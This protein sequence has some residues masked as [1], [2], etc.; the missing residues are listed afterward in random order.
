MNSEDLQEKQKKAG[1]PIFILIIFV[2]LI[3]FVFYVPEI[4]KKYNSEI[5]KFFGIKDPDEEEREKYEGITPLSAYY[6]IGSK[7]TFNYN[8]ITVSDVSLS[9]EKKLS[10][11]IG[12]KDTFDLDK[13]GY[14]IEF[15]KGKK[16][17]IGRRALHG[18]VTKT[19]PI[20]LDL[21]N[22]DV[23]TTTY[24]VLSHIDDSAIGGSKEENDTGLYVMTCQD[25]NESY[26][27]EFYMKKLNK[28]TY[29]YNYSNQNL[30]EYSMA[31]LEYQKKEKDLTGTKGVST[32]IAESDGSFIYTAEFDYSEADSFSKVKDKNLYEKG[33]YNHIIK[34]KSEAEGF[35]C[36]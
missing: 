35:D 14:Y 5:N 18:M 7:D 36:K 20:E 33:S 25:K 4:Y 31:L 13:S 32:S 12:T 9:P 27:Y 29:K 23:D 6:M 22:L 11:M 15:Y 10:I 30:D 3:G 8:E 21:S 24:Y 28:V 17:F 2:V 16:T 19:L 34:F 1:N 26:T